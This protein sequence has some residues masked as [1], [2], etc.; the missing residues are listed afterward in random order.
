M[1]EFLSLGNIKQTKMFFPNASEYVNAI[2]AY[3][4]EV[5]NH[6]NRLKSARFEMLNDILS[7]M[8]TLE[9]YKDYE[10]N[11]EQLLNMI[12]SFKVTENTIQKL[13]SI[14]LP[15]EIIRTIRNLI[16]KSFGDH[17]EYLSNLAGKIQKEAL[18]EYQHILMKFSR[19]KCFDKI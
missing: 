18:E 2:K 9:Q 1:N 7:E 13:E 5:K 6:M 10:E 4:E 15:D 11:V 14:H 17:T 8:K 19:S 12:H 16:G 3:F